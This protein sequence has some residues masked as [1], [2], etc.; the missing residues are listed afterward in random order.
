MKKA[1]KRKPT[2][3]E[4]EQSASPSA[5]NSP[6]MSEI[7]PDDPKGSADRRFLSEDGATCGELNISEI[8]VTWGGEKFSPVQYMTVDVGPIV[9]RVRC[10]PN[11]RPN[12]IVRRLTK[13]L[14]RYGN[15]MFESKVKAHLERVKTAATLADR[16]KE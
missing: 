12:Q 4:P 7:D 13:Q 1:I 16:M 14:E 2:A 11:E 10:D 9:A 5:L 8:E 3:A 6:E 15:E